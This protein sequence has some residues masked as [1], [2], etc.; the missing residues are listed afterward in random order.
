MACDKKKKFFERSS[1]AQIRKDKERVV[2]EMDLIARLEGLKN[3]EY[4]EIGLDVFRFNTFGG[5]KRFMKNGPAVNFGTFRSIDEAVKLGKTPMQRLNDAFNNPVVRTKYRNGYTFK[6]VIGDD[7]LTRVVHLFEVMEAARLMAYGKA[8]PV[9]DIAIKKAY[10]SASAVNREGGKYLV[11]TPSRRKKRRRHNFT[12][13]GIPLS[14]S[15]P[16]VFVS[17]YSFTSENVAVES[18][19]MRELK[20]AWE[21]EV[22]TG[23]FH[24]VQAHEIAA[25]YAVAEEE[26]G[27]GNSTPFE[28]L[29]F[30]VP[31]QRAVDLY[32]A[33]SNQTVIQ[34]R[35]TDNKLSTRRLRQE[36]LEVLLWG[37]GFKLGLGK[38]FDQRSLIE[39]RLRD[40]RWL[41]STE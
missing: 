38:L 6:P 30:P 31:S 17:P 22:E 1:E 14:R 11:S 25:A 20:F 41:E 2:V 15:E 24:Y 8:M 13:G 35:G 39:G 4:A 33:A 16:Y 12:I 3:E 40:Y 23:D 32:L 37:L 27:V 28:F 7:K 26:M 34:T 10:T 5:F 9:A 29:V 18:K 36:E 19:T 21:E